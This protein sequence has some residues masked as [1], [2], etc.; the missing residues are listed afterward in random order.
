VA[1]HGRPKRWQVVAAVVAIVA[2]VAAGTLAVVLVNHHPAG[3][4]SSAPVKSQHVAPL[5]VPEAIMQRNANSDGAVDFEGALQL[6]S[7]V[8]A[9]LPGVTLPAGAQDDRAQWADLAA[10]LIAANFNELT[11]AQRQVVLPYL[12]D[13]GG[14][15]A[16]LSST[17][18]RSGTSTAGAMLTDV[19]TMGAPAPFVR[20]DIALLVLKAL[21]AEGARLGHGLADSP[22][23]ASLSHV[24]L[25]LAAKDL[26]IKGGGTGAAWAS[27]SHGPGY[28]ANGDILPT[29]TTVGKITDCYIFVGPKIWNSTDGS[30]HWVSSDRTVAMIYHEVFH[31]YQEFVVGSVS[32]TVFYAAPSWIVEGGATWAAASILPY[33]EPAWKAYLTTPGT[34]LSNRAYDAF[35]FFF[36][37]EYVGRPLWPQW[38]G[39][40]TAAAVGGWG[41]ADWFNA[42]AG[43]HRTALI[44]AWG[45]SFY[46]D[47]SLGHDWTVTGNGQ[48]A[49]PP[50]P[51]APSGFGGQLTINSPPYATAQVVIPPQKSGTIVVSATVSATFRILDSAQR[52]KIGVSYLA[53]C[54]GTCRCPGATDQPATFA[55]SG[56]VDWAT[57]SQQSYSQTALKAT[58]VS[59][60][61]KTKPSDW[62]P[63]APNTCLKQCPG[64][65]GDPHMRTVNLRSFEFQAAGEYELLRSA[66]GTVEIQGR[67]E[68]T[69]GAGSTATI[70]T[71]VAVRIGTHRVGVYAPGGAQVLDVHVDGS[72]VPL[73]APMDLSGGGRLLR[74]PHGVEIDLPDGTALWALFT[75]GRWGINLEMTPS[76]RLQNSAVGV[77]GPIALGYSVPMLPDGTGMHISAD[78]V[79]QYN[80]RYQKFAPAWRVT[81]ATSLFDYDPGKSTKSYTVAGFV[82]QGGP[83]KPLEF[84]PAT[85][86]ASETTCSPIADVDL[87]N[88]C[89]YDVT[90]TGDPGFVT[91]YSD[92]VS[93]FTGSGGPSGAPPVVQTSPTPSVSGTALHEILAGANQRGAV[94]G[95][96]GSLDILAV[97]GNQL[98]VIAVDPATS[99]IRLQTTIAPMLGITV[100]TGLASSAGSLW[101]VVD[102]GLETC[103]VDQL[104][105]VTLAVQNTMPLPSCPFSSPAI[106]GTADEVWTDDSS[107][108]L[109][110][111]D[112][113]HKTI[114]ET[115]ATAGRGQTTPGLFASESSVFW[116]TEAG[117]Y[118]VDTQS[119]SLVQIAFSSDLPFPVGDG[120]WT[121]LDSADVG[122]YDNNPTAPTSTLA[123]PRDLVGAD[124]N[125]VYTEDPT[126]HDVL[127]YPIDGSPGGALGISAFPAIHLLIGQHNAFNVLAKA[128]QAGAA[129][130][131][132]VENFPLP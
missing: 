105:P 7:Y 81:D 32:G 120:V 76:A 35:A 22:A 45:A 59:N 64:S 80:F 16:P 29:Y 23:L 73:S 69:A 68:P 116:E 54:W 132:Y 127:R 71:A 110:R 52:E 13:A 126:T 37:I 25:F 5:T 9:P 36:E 103:S 74:S 8:F 40:W 21:T 4:L 125:N 114:S 109:E 63:P 6:F 26:V 19:R 99:A 3:T 104:N 117:I 12:T 28:D 130:A 101:L 118:R 92:T 43:D 119:S 47:P 111:I 131:I 75:T 123:V 72:L 79:A 70:N 66:D 24:Y 96:D 46:R 44:N 49:S 57:A 107:G 20:T 15:G 98:S 67:Q 50:T 10:S 48:L 112:M 91:A 30:G 60:Y 124:A 11:A 89:V 77:L 34:A 87:R 51:A 106:A 85:L 17:Q 83:P 108:R 56:E 1:A 102:T 14:D 42:V 2:V 128:P 65:N 27:P 82:P 93:F 53:M 33:D 18:T 84:D 58:N 113:A 61:C 115:I 90:A 97:V 39:I 31:C 95:P 121:T 94:V 41:N 55:V 38:W 86:A 78:A 88:D 62:Q 100:P 129:L 122:F